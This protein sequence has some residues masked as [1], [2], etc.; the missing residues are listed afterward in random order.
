MSR[1]AERVTRTLSSPWPRLSLLAILLAAVGLFTLIEGAEAL[2]TAEHWVATL[3]PFGVPALTAI[4]AVLTA[5]LFP[6][7]LLAIASGALFG[8]LL[9]TGIV[10]SGSVLGAMISF[11]L[12]RAL[13]R[14]ALQQIVGARADRLTDFLM[15]RGT[16]AIC[17]ARLI[18]VVPYWL[19]N[20][21]VALTRLTRHQYIIGTAIGTLP[22]V[23]LWVVLGGS[24]TDP[25]SPAFLISAALLL[26]LVLAGLVVIRR[27][28]PPHAP[29]DES[30]PRASAGR[31][32]DRR[33]CTLSAGPPRPER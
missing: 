31:V 10:W 11:E 33:G 5:A 2:D 8:P 12:A 25:T 30:R 23:G 29:E 20:Y 19:I 1:T 21:G 22:G 3:G 27:S 24:L 15:R 9:G 26:G 16:L 4:V 17:F 13:S 18:P 32:S 14:D 7:T 28:R 6:V